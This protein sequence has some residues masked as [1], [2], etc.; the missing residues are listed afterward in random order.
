MAGRLWCFDV[1]QLPCADCDVALS[2]QRG[3]VIVNV[4]RDGTE[5]EIAS[6]VVEPVNLN[7]KEKA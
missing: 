7:E 1:I 4:S 3:V 2:E 5:F 6:V